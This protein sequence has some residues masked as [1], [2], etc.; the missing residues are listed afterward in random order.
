MKLHPGTQQV[1]IVSGTPLAGDS[2]EK[3]ARNDL[4]GF[5]DA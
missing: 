5:N 2:W 3:L 4:Q 1:F